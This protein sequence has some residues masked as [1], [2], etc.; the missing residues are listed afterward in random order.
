[1][2]DVPMSRSVDA[3]D[4]AVYDVDLD[5]RGGQLSRLLKLRYEGG[6]ELYVRL[7]DIGDEWMD[8]AG[9]IREVID[10][11]AVCDGGRVFPRRMNR[12]TTP[13]LWSVRREVLQLM[14]DHNAAS[15]RRGGAASTCPSPVPAQVTASPRRAPALPSYPKRLVVMGQDRLNFGRLD[16]KGV[17]PALRAS[18]LRFVSVAGSGCLRPP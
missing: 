4:D 14:D 7:D 1:V 13:R 17:T 10:H 11:G 8:A 2:T 18:R 9:V 6:V 15:M 3:F 5:A 12:S 16:T